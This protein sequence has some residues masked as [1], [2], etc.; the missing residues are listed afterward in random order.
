MSAEHWCWHTF[1][2]D[3]YQYLY[4]APFLVEMCSPDGFKKQIKNGVGELVQVKLTIINKNLGGV[5]VS[6][7]VKTLGV[8]A[9]G[10]SKEKED[11]G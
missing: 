10:Y 7:Y 3:R 8:S 1:E 2:D 11:R 5:G 6:D 9:S 4:R